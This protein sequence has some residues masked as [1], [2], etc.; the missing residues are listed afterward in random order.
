L[1]LLEAV[2]E[3]KGAGNGVEHCFGCGKDVAVG[4]T[5]FVS[6][7]QLTIAQTHSPCDH[8]KADVVK[9]AVVIRR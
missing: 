5:K 2:G 9:F 4:K 1:T 3:H 8:F 6:L 7:K